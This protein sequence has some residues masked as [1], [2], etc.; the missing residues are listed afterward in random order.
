LTSKAA[1]AAELTTAVCWCEQRVPYSCVV[2]ILHA[3]IL[4]G[5]HPTYLVAK[6]VRWATDV[7]I[8]EREARKA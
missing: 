2:A 1:A 5:L 7:L 8:R 3:P 4:T 6:L